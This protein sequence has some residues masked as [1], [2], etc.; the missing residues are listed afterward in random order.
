M[1]LTNENNIGT[2]FEEVDIIESFDDIINRFPSPTEDC[3]P[4]LKI[5]G[6]NS[7][8]SKAKNIKLYND[9]QEYRKD[10]ILHNGLSDTESVGITVDVV[11]IDNII[12]DKYDG[13]YDFH[14]KIIWYIWIYNDRIW[15][16]YTDRLFMGIYSDGSI[17]FL[18]YNIFP[19]P[20][21]TRMPALEI[22]TNNIYDKKY[23]IELY[24]NAQKWR[25]SHN[26]L[27]YGFGGNWPEVTK[28]FVN[29]LII[30]G[31]IIDEYD[32][33]YNYHIDIYYERIILLNDH[34]SSE[35]LTISKDGS[36]TIT[37]KIPNH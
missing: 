19:S 14:D 29:K 35:V 25:L 20:G 1:I 26:I 36:V 7:D 6:D 31:S 9:A 8:Q 22:N 21:E 11:L 24:N 32:E 12:M 28:M 34:D 13:D 3:M 15:L 10:Y 2:E 4:S 17:N 30:D 23:N 16:F 27:H 18:R 37:G 5:Y 33:G